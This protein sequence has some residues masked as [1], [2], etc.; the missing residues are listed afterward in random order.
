MTLSCSR[1]WMT[2]RFVLCTSAAL[3]AVRF[4]V[5]GNQQNGVTVTV[6]IYGRDRN[7]AVFI[8]GY[9]GS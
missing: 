9:A 5:A 7:F 1:A 2:I 4:V 3:G 8:H 6:G